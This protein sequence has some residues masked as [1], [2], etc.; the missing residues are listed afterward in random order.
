MRSPSS[1][2]AASSIC[3]RLLPERAKGRDMVG[4]PKSAELHPG[5]GFRISLDAELPDP[6]IVT[7]FGAFETPAISDLMNRLYTMVPDI[8]PLTDPGLRILGPACTVRVYPGD[9]LM[10]HKS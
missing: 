3:K 1:C 6:A 9:N 4:K 8:R 10:V 5:P 2:G 7:G